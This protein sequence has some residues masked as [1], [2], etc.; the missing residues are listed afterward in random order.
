VRPAPL[1]RKLLRDLLRL[2]WQVLAIALLG[3]ILSAVF[4]ALF[5]HDGARDELALIMS[6]QSFDPDTAIIFHDAF[7]AVI[8][9][10][11][12]MAILAGV[13]GGL[14]APGRHRAE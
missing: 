8:L 2:K 13:I 9:T 11:A 14:T 3:V 6:G 5:A 1:D 4:S 7:R 12:G 10:C